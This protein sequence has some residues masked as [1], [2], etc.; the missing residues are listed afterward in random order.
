MLAECPDGLGQPT[1]LKWFEEG[2]SR[3]LEARLRNA[4]EV[5]GQTAWSLLMK[6]E[7]YRIH[8]VSDLPDGEVRHMRM[9]PAHS[10]ADV[11]DGLDHQPEGYIMQRGAA[12]LPLLQERW[13]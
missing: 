7:R 6:A 10:L 12:L 13:F 8:L 5:N 3:A 2:D 1:F 4:Y 11:V 9:I